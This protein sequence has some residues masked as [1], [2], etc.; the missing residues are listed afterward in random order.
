M[1]INYVHPSVS[2]TI[3]DNSTVY[4]TASGTTKLFAVFTSE[5]GVDNK[6]Q[7]ITSVSEFVFNYG[8]NLSGP[9]NRNIASFKLASSNRF[10]VIRSSPRPNPPCG[11]QPYLKN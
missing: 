6:I 1:A 4:I 5:K 2:S 10:I 9:R 3:T 7:T 11:G 8:V